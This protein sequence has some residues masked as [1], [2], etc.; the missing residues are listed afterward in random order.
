V[1][2]ECHSLFKGRTV[3]RI[4]TLVARVTARPTVDG[5][6]RNAERIKLVIKGVLLWLLAAEHALE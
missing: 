3:G 2:C 5:S 1:T 6:N 4:P